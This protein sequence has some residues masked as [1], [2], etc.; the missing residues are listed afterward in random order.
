MG[1]CGIEV[2]TL[3][4]DA[5]EKDRYYG[6]CK[7]GRIAKLRQLEKTIQELSQGIGTD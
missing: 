1:V 3:G 6:W 4:N 2:T 5:R 7:S